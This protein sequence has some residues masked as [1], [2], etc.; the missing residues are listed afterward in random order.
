[1]MPPPRTPRP[2]QKSRSRAPSSKAA[3]NSEADARLHVLRTPILPDRIRRI[4]GQG[5]SFI[6]HRFL[7]DGFLQFL[8]RDELALYLFLVLAGN[9]DGVSFYRYDAICSVLSATLDDFIQARNRLIEKDLIAFDGSRFQVLSLPQG[10][11]QPPAK[12]LRSK[13]DF[14]QRDPATIR[15]IIRDVLDPPDLP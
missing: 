7:R 14:E 12:P 9:R 4:A 3:R 6:P 8:S 11:A 10:R 5:F 1:M 15:A 13:A 2:P